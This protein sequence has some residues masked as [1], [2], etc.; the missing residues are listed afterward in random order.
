M[1]FMCA[2]IPARRVLAGERAGELAGWSRAPTGWRWSGGPGGV[3]WTLCNGQGG[4]HR[5]ARSKQSSNS[6]S[7]AASLQLLPSAGGDVQLRAAGERAFD[8]GQSAGGS[9]RALIGGRGTAAGG[10]V[11]RALASV[12]YWA[13]SGRPRAPT[14]LHPAQ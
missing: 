12:P 13:C 8:G 2:R 6:P 7:T 3:C 4:E 10:G 5:A 11:A 9:T 1:V 14:W